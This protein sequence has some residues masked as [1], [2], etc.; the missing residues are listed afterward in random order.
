MF[1]PSY[2]PR[3]NSELVSGCENETAAL[4]EGAA[5]S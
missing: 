3:K 1:S 5:G 2:L 4:V